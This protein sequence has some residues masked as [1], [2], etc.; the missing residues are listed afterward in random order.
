MRKVISIFAVLAVVAV[1]G[2]M[3]ACGGG[4]A[5][6]ES[7]NYTGENTP[8]ILDTTGSVQ[9]ARE[10]VLDTMEGESLVD[11]DMFPL[12]LASSDALDRFLDPDVAAGILINALTGE[13]AASPMVVQAEPLGYRCISGSESG[14]EGVGSVRGRIC[15]DYNEAEETFDSVDYLEGTFINYSDDGVEYFQGTMIIDLRSGDLRMIMRDFSFDD[16]I[17]ELF[18]DG[19]V[20]FTESGAVTS[21]RF[22]MFILF[23]DEGVWFNDL[24]LAEE[25]LVTYITSSINGRI[26][27]FVDGYIDFVT[28]EELVTNDGDFY[29][30]EGI[31][32]LTG[33]NGVSI[34][35]EVVDE[36]GFMVYVDLDGDGSSDWQTSSPQPWAVGG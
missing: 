34:T 25:D 30:S 21:V 23:N 4:G 11:P 18:L 9:L 10:A 2:T 22:N 6:S 17:D 1:L 27:D 7:V 3:V 31:I 32:K 28:I 20:S 26:Y 15:G 13:P 36:T 19:I 35:L 8:A 24:V 5:S 33:A 16:G 14:F 12:A 29:P